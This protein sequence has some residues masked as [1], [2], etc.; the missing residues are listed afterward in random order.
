MYDATLSTWSEAIAYIESNLEAG[1]T[2]EIDSSPGE[3]S[4]TLQTIHGAKGLEY[5]IVFCANMNRRAF[6]HYGKPSSGTI[7]Y[8]DPIGLRQRSVFDD[9]N[10]RPYV[11]K[12]WSYDLLTGC[13]PSEYDEERRLFYVA[14]TRAKRHLFFTAGDNPSSFFTELS[15]DSTEIDPSVTAREPEEIDDGAFSVTVP[16]RSR[17]RRLSVH[18]IMDDSVYDD[19]DEGRGTE[20]GDRLHQFAEDYVRGSD[21]SPV[22]NDQE[23]VKTLLDSLDGTFKPEITAILPLDLEPQITLVGIIDL[24]VIT[25]E[26]I[27]IIDY[28]TDLGRHAE[29]EYRKQLSVYYHVVAN[30]Y[31]NRDISIH[32]L[33]TAD[34]ETVELS[35]LT[36]TELQEIT[37]SANKAR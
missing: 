32:I 16:E 33:Y 8:R 28:K 14:V 13:L 6:P 12:H 20:F 2:V 3:D 11:Y 18:D 22:G 29:S 25:P 27:Q 36:I 24:L 35:P 1:S 26:Q 23:N 21:V 10:G 34:D 5:P 7:Q 37:E 17:S 30:E 4:V 9:A 31:P 15:V 19:V